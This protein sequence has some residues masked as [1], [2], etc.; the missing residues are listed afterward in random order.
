MV[1]D[2]LGW[3]G[4]LFLL[5][6][7]LALVSFYNRCPKCHRR[8]ALEFRGTIIKG[9]GN[10]FELRVCKYCGHEVERGNGGGNGG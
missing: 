6:V 7:V 4:L 2:D 10:K 5:F 1:D 9:D 3:V 8:F